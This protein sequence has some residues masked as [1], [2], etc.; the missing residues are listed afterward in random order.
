MHHENHN[1]KDLKQKKVETIKP[2]TTEE[3]KDMIKQMANTSPGTDSCSAKMLKSLP[4]EG[5]ETICKL[6][7]YCLKGGTLPEKWKEGQITLI[8]KKGAP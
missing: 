5:V 2:F 8:Y 1:R 7:N 3:V 6:Y 4:P